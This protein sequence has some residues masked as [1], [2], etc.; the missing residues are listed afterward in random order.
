MLC[1]TYAV[2]TILHET[3]RNEQQC[4]ATFN[5][6]IDNYLAAIQVSAYRGRKAIQYKLCT[7]YI[8][9]DFSTYTYVV[10]QMLSGLTNLNVHLPECTCF[11][12][13]TSPSSILINQSAINVCSPI[14]F[15]VWIHSYCI[16]EYIFLYSTNDTSVRLRPR[17]GPLIDVLPWAY[18]RKPFIWLPLALA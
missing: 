12:F 13:L 9:H 3:A 15:K 10:P 2:Y 16:Y 4:L 1:A 6:V 11:P 7:L 14:I 5:Y 18:V 17:L 8:V